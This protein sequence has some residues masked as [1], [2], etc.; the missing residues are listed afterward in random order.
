[1]KSGERTGDV[2]GKPIFEALPII[3]GQ[4]FEQLLEQ[5][6]TSGERVTVPEMRAELPRNGRIE[7]VF[8]NF[9]Y[10]PMIESSG[11]VIGIMAVATDIT[12]QVIAR[13]KI[14]RSEKQLR[15]VSDLMPQMVW[16][17]DEAG[18]HKY[19][20]QQWY[21]F[22]QSDYEGAR[23]E[24]WFQYFHPE[25]KPQASEK[26]RNSLQTGKIYEM[27]FRLKNGNSGNYS[28]VLGRAVPIR[29]ADGEIYKWFGTCTD[30][31]EYKQQEL[32][33]DDFIGIASHELKTP[34]TTVKASLQLMQRFV[35]S[36]S[37][38]DVLQTGGSINK[39]CP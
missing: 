36:S 3:K 17:T 18:A 24:G 26:W 19:F 22:T 30:I 10:E 27:E 28:W 2:I 11:S 34:L 9:V 20:N 7:R 35:K 29:D 13:Q 6:Y 12:E 14:E 16:V 32:Q 39:R 5:V 8:L 15:Q 4:G 25:D 33:K 31:H 21:D 37:S 1:M 38:S 23:N